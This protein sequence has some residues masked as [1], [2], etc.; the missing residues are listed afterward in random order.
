MKRHTITGGDGARLHLVETGNSTGRPILFLHGFSQCWLAWSRQLSSGLADR[1]RL[2]GMDLR[3][4][5]LSDKPRDGYGDSKLWADDVNAAIQDLKLDRPVLCGWSYGPLVILDYVRHYG[6]EAIGGMAFVDG[7]TKL[8]SDE[9]NS[10][11]SQEF[12]SLVPGFFA[13]DAESAAESLRSLLLLCLSQ[14]P[15]TEELYLML[16]YNL[17][18]PPYVRQALFSRSFDNDDLLPTIR[19]PVLIVHGAEDRVVKPA[20]VNQHKALV[21]HAQVQMIPNAGHAP[22]WDEAAAFNGHLRAFCERLE[23]EPVSVL[24]GTGRSRSSEPA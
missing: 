14:K 1:Y 8:G 21:A 2:I 5:G 13:P 22:F 3:G 19:K 7:I 17:S 6:E 18:V 9:A 10:V 23:V 15:S 12:L 4:H 16:G 11:I 20:I 24:K